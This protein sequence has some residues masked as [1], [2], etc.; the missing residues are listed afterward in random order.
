M[1]T[2]CSCCGVT[3]ERESGFYLGSI[4]FNYGLTALIAAIFYPV[5][6]FNRVLPSHLLMPITLA[7]VLLFPLW[8]FRYARALWLGFDQYWDPRHE[9]PE[10]E[11][12]AEGSAH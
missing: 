2:R 8:F 1:H 6:W 4:Y 11:D 5:L 9:Q 7:F 10:L 3:F 12:A